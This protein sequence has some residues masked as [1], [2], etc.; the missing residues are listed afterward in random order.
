VSTVKKLAGC[1]G[2]PARVQ[3]FVAMPLRHFSGRSDSSVPQRFA[4]IIAHQVF[5]TTV[6]TQVMPNQALEFIRVFQQAASPDAPTRKTTIRPV[7]LFGE[8]R[9]LIADVLVDGGERGEAFE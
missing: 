8:I 5:Q 6:H 7:S 2:I 4:E 3:S 9:S 1:I